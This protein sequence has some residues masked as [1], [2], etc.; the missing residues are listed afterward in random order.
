MK[1][2]KITGISTGTSIKTKLI[3]L[4]VLLL[5]A[6]ITAVKVYDYN[7]RVPQIESEVRNER[8]LSASLVASRLQTE[9]MQSVVIIETSAINSV[10]A[11]DDN[12]AIV[13]ALQIVKKQNPLF[14]AVF[15]ADENLTRINE[16]GE[17]VSL[18]SREYM[19]QVKATKKTVISRETLLSKTTNNLSVMMTTPIKVAGSPER[20]LGVAV[21]VT[22]FQNTVNDQKKSA[23]AYAFLFDGKDGT[24]FAHPVKEYIGTLKLINTDDKDKGKVAPELR[25]MALESI[26]GK[27]G[28]AVYDFNGAKIVAAYTNI[29]GTAFGVATRMTYE[30][31]MSSI[32]KERLSA[33]LITLF[34]ALIGGILAFIFARFIANP[35]ITI[36]SQAEII[37][38]GDFTKAS[39]I[40]IERNDEI[41]QLQQS[42][43]EMATMLKATMISISQTSV[44][45]ADFSE[46]LNVGAANSAQGATQVANTAE[47]V[48]LGAGEQTSAVDKTVDMVKEIDFS[49]DE[50]A[51]NAITVA[52]LSA[53]ALEV[54]TTGSRSVSHAVTQMGT[55]NITVQNTATVIRELGSASDQIEQIVQTITAI[56]GQTNLLA[57]N[58]AIEAARAGEQGRGFAVVADEVR[59]LAEQS[60]DSANTITQIVGNI[61]LQTKD[62]IRK[63]DHSAHEVLAGEQVVLAAGQSFQQI[64]NK[65]SKVN[66]SVQGITVA[67]RQLATSSNNVIVAVEKVKDISHGAVANSQ[68]IS[69]AAAQ[70]S[71]NMQEISTAAE[72]LAHL[73]SQLESTVNEYKF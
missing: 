8:M 33:L 71:T 39:T 56:A 21:G 5:V 50:I 4:I 63:M 27:S 48:A 7:I 17:S 14:E 73:A 3:L 49:I 40:M 64:E 35:V 15:L 58:A 23:S 1:Q 60:K 51:S 53:E 45:V 44:K 66:E 67:A 9:L 26:D 24:I 2:K 38:A 61:Q 68:T 55:I 34:V 11:S 72:S 54:A 18:A 46:Q 69:A 25:Q 30:E 19:Q 10:F 32:H 70:Q 13:K 28:T 16:K 12:M 36:A 6:T 41:G 57:L 65:I 29:P 22:A 20:Y 42:F 43:K 37:A 31:A 59:K 62:A 52:A 47:E